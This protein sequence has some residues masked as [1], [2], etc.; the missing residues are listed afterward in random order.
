MW[1][2]GVVTG[3]K[4]Y[5][6]RGRLKKKFQIKYIIVLSVILIAQ[7]VVLFYYGDRKSGFHEDELYSYY[8][9]NKTAGL[10]VNDG[11]W[12]TGEEFYHE[13]AVLPG[14]QFRYG[15]VKQMQSWDVHPPLYYYLLHT[16]CS[17]TSGVFSKWQGISVNLVGFVLSFWLLAYVSYLLAVYP[18]SAARDVTEERKV[19]LQKR[20]YLLAVFT[21]LIWGFGAAVI[22]GVLFIR[23]YQWLTVFVL[24]CLCLHLRY[25][26]T[27]RQTQ[28][29]T[30]EIRSGGEGTTDRKMRSF[31]EWSFFPALGITVFLG[32]LTQYYYIIFHFFLGAGFCLYLLKEKEWKRLLA[33]VGTCA[34]SLGSALLYYPSALSHIFRGYRGTE[35]VGEF[36]DASNTWERLSFFTGLF[37][38]YMTGGLLAVLLLGLCLLALTRRALRKRGR[39][40]EK[41]MTVPAALVM[42][43]ALGYFFTVSK[44]ALLLG[45]TS[46]RYELPVYGLLVL[47]L[48]YS[49]Y[50][51]VQ[52][53]VS[54]GL[55]GDAA[56]YEKQ[57]GATAAAE[58][59][60]SYAAAAVTGALALVLIV[61]NLTGDKVFFLYEEERVMSEFI[62]EHTDAPVIVLYNEASETHIWWLLD[63]LCQ[64]ENIYFASLGNEEPLATSES[65]TE[66]LQELYGDGADPAEGGCKV[67][68]YVADYDGQQE[69]MTALLSDFLPETVESG[70]ETSGENNTEAVA[71]SPEHPEDFKEIV[72]KNMWTVYEINLKL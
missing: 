71:D 40:M 65:F 1:S 23:M 34:V 15:V 59:K 50:L 38:D 37:D 66:Q 17:L 45:E 3:R 29:S 39:G 48:V 51:P 41:V 9:S 69:R 4:G 2:Y 43:A 28:E 61:G 21:C 6:E 56:G 18:L 8:S 54:G 22:S 5:Q 72:Q 62:K 25:L 52:E 49:L 46:N 58:R 11:K 10:F 14:E 16:V 19:M 55:T 67:V 32:F 12:M 31:R 27:I 13:L 42:T 68:V 20:G 60:G 57:K 70:A 35:A 47:L 30:D 24:L 7:L 64:Y 33:Y 26:R 53:L 63:E 44:T 36:T